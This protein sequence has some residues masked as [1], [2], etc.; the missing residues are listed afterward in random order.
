MSDKAFIGRQVDYCASDLFQKSKNFKVI[1]VL[2][3]VF[4]TSFCCNRV[5]WN[6][7]AVVAY[8]FALG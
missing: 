1:C 5:A 3:I 6:A 4:V 8:A 2:R 7:C